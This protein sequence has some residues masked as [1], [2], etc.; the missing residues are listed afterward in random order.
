MTKHIENAT[1]SL[2]YACSSKGCPHKKPHFTW[3]MDCKKYRHCPIIQKSV[4]C[5]KSNII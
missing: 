5:T 3:G 4:K 2:S 1:C